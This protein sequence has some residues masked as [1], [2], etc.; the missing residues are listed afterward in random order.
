MDTL[1]VTDEFCSEFG[2]ELIIGQS[3]I[4][5]NGVFL[6]KTLNIKYIYPKISDYFF[7]PNFFVS[8]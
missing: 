7:I 3:K 1:L 4:A 8:F 2:F 6:A 5:G